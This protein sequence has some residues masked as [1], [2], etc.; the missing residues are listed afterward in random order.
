MSLE[1]QEK[2]L[3]V[4]D[5]SLTLN[6]AKR[7]HQVIINDEITDIVF[8][9]GKDKILP[10]S[11]AMKFSKE[12]FRIVHLESDAEVLIPRET[13]VGAPVQLMPD[14]VIARFTE[15]SFDALR[16]R[17]VILPGGEKFVQEGVEI[18]EMVD[19]LM[20]KAPVAESADDEELGELEHEEGDDL[21]EI[22][23]DP[24]QI[25]ADTEPNAEDTAPA[26][27]GADTAAD[28]TADENATDPQGEVAA[29]ASGITEYKEGA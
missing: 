21:D 28:T 16:T 23:G 7:I 6:N 9:Y 22:N 12:G 10:E 29:D 15:L 17:C 13:P 4:I 5:S 2:F 11:V 1:S 18:Q 14:E 25:P 20:G 27:E 19:F 26:T 24:K 3:K 8:E